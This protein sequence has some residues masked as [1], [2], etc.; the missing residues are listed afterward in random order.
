MPCTSFFTCGLLL[1]KEIVFASLDHIGAINIHQSRDYKKQNFR[2]VPHQGTITNYFVNMRCIGCEAIVVGSNK[3]ELLCPT[4]VMNPQ[5]T[6]LNLH[7]KI[8]ESDRRK[9]ELHNICLSCANRSLRCQSL[10]CPVIYSRLSAESDID[11]L[12]F[13]NQAMQIIS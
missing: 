12:C 6:V 4:C 5:K 11:A 13:V 9:H 7:K 1:F 2:L 3:S 8:Y 10:D